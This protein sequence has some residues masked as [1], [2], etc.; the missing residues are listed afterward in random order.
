M[1][2]ATYRY[3]STKRAEEFL[4]DASGV[5]ALLNTLK[6]TLDSDLPQ[7][8]Q[9]LAAGDVQGLNDLLHQFKGFAPLF[10]V[11][12]LADRVVQVE[13]LSKQAPLEALTQA[14]EPLLEQLMVLQSEVEHQLK[15]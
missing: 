10:C 11:D 12:S 8:R 14:M 4:G 9:R 1:S 5:N 6:N 3:L 13:A 7:L 2:S 15:T